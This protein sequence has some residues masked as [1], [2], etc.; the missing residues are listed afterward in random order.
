MK[1]VLVILISVL[2]I[3]AQTDLQRWVKADFHYSKGPTENKRDFSLSSENAASY[4]LKAGAS[5]YWVF[6]SDVDG[7]NC[8][9]YPS[10]STFFIESVRETNILQ[11]TLMFFDRFTRD[12]NI[13]ERHKH[14]PVIKKGRLY[15]PAVLYTLNDKR[16]LK[17]LQLKYQSEN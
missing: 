2:S 5:V 16:T 1:T 7:D 4:L 8:P 10:C 11:G 14:Y 13:A 6:I 17:G 3:A 15:D 9:F 12:M